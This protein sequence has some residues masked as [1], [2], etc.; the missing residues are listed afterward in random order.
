[1]KKIN[2]FWLPDDDEY[3]AF[4]LAKG[5]NG[6]QTQHLVEALG[7][8]EYLGV[9]IDVGAHVGTYSILMAEHFDKVYSIEAD[10][11]NFCCLCRNIYERRLWNITPI[12]AVANDKRKELFLTGQRASTEN[13]SG[14]NQVIKTNDEEFAVHSIIIDDLGLPDVNFIKFDI[15]GYEYQALRGLIDTIRRC[16]P[17]IFIELKKMPNNNFDLTNVKDFLSYFNYKPVKNWTDNWLFE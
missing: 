17:F 5:K 6:V 12:W 3:Y 8:V 1:M 10:F 11:T 15:E 7:F 14:Q 9:G 16:N 13:N 2:N 4:H